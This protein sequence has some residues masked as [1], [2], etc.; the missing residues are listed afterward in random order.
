[1]VGLNLSSSTTEK[2]ES[3]G[4]S[5]DAS[6]VVVSVIFALVIVV[7]GGMRFYIKTQNDTLVEL[8]ATL[9]QSSSQL[10]GDKVNRVAY[11][12][13]RLGFMQQQLKGNPVD[14]KMLLGQLESLTVPQAR[15]T[16]YEYDGV[17]KSVEVAGEAENFKFVAEQML[18]LKSESLFTGIKVDLLE[19]TPEG[20]IKFSFK[21]QF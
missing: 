1:M 15:L 3:G 4:M 21:S 19:R 17:K 9:K 10:Q 12:D 7:F 14:S 8:D 5:L 6:F 16:K 18:G 13:A 2:K 20:R 11:F